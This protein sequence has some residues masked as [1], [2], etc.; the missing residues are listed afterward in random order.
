MEARWLSKV[1]LLD[2]LARTCGL[3]GLS[4]AALYGR[5]PSARS[6]QRMW[7]LPLFS[8]LARAAA[9][10]YYRV[11]YTGDPVP[12]TGPVLLVANH[13]NSLLD[14]MLVVAAA[15]RPVRFLAK[16]PLFE[17]ARIGWL[18]RAAGAIPIYRRG[19]DATQMARNRGTF[20]SAHTALARG[21]AVGIFPEGVSHNAPS[22]APLRTGAARIAL[23]ACAFTGTTFPIVPVGLVHREKDVFRSEAH[24]LTG[25]P[26][27][28]DDLVDGSPAPALPAPER[29]P[30]S[31]RPTASGDAIEADSEPLDRDAVRVLTDR[32]ENALRQITL[33]LERWEDRPLVECAVRIWEAGQPMAPDPRDRVARL[34]V[35][36][37]VLSAVRA[38]ADMEG[39]TLAREVNAHRRQLE[40]LGLRPADLG[41]DVSMSRGIRWAV[42][43]AH[44]LLPLG[45][46]MAVAGFALFWPPY[47]VTGFLVDRLRLERDLRST[48][49][50]LAGIVFHGLWLIVLALLAGLFTSGIRGVVVAVVM[51]IAGIT[52]LLV[53][54][55][56]RMAWS[57][58]RRFLLLRSRRELV[59][60]LR[61]RQRVLG[62][63]LQA[64]LAAYTR[65]NGLRG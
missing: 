38:R 21:D 22:L 48:W 2:P 4:P 61:E 17:D 59:A 60:A 13:P 30:A 53:R 58:A 7:L 57:D 46:T 41:A 26:V 27:P 15:R 52:G 18:I 12:R 23:G 35:T 32:L 55:R 34:E 45:A 40:R 11:R 1:L 43:R 16:A 36:T 51:P 47:R 8:P 39:L 63:R 20:R 33:N 31:D 62:D 64:L 28:W 42:R 29:H 44:L 24:V 10:I 3:D 14:P 19:D 50:L 37:R 56:W 65:Q 25:P 49:K 9:Y 6:L 5:W 54:D